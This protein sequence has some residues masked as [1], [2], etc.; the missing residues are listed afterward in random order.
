MADNECVI[1]GLT[2]SSKSVFLAGRKGGPPSLSNWNLL[3]AIEH[4]VGDGREDVDG[5]RKTDSP[6]PIHPY[7]RRHSWL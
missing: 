4:R 7:S 5:E 6:R 2:K 3:N 1:A